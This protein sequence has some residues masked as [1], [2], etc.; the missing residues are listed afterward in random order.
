MPLG[1]G[2]ATP[3][4]KKKNRLAIGGGW[5]TPVG[6]KGGFDHP[7]H[8]RLA[9][10]GWP[11]P[12]MAAWPLGAVWPLPKA[13]RFFFFL[14]FWP[15]GVAGPPPRAMGGFGHPRPAIFGHPNPQ[16]GWSGHPFFIIYFLKYKIIFYYYF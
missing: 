2:L 15:L 8:P 5:S 16:L 14:F 4:G 1:G 12:P 9:S 7:N 11:W 13:K 3:N 10:L 6:P